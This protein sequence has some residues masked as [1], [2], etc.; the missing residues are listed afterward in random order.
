LKLSNNRRYDNSENMTFKHKN[1][2]TKT[3][4]KTKSRPGKALI[5]KAI[6]MPGFLIES[7]NAIE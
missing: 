3:Q 4:K 6:H 7:Y 2:E 1:A 5:V